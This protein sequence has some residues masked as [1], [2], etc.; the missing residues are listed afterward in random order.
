MLRPFQDN[1][2]ISRQ[3]ATVHILAAEKDPVPQT[4]SVESVQEAEVMLPE[5]LR[6]DLW[7]AETL[8]RLARAYWAYVTKIVLGLIRIVY[9]PDS[10]TVVLLSKRIP[11]LR[12]HAPEFE[13]STDG[14]GGTVRW[15]IDRGLLVAKE[16]EGRGALEISVTQLPDDERTGPDWDRVHA[17]VAVENFYPWLRGKGSFARIGAWLYARTQLTIHVIVCN[18]FLRSLAKL[19]FPEPM[20]APDASPEQRSR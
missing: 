10:T 14:S 5:H 16:G 3:P 15:P 13:V 2:R 7:K 9:S 11:L 20:V 12:F 4:G 19:E 18:G 17:R 6:E 8:E 1:R